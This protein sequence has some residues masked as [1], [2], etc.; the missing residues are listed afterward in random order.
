VLYQA[1]LRPD[2]AVSLRFNHPRFGCISL[3]S[4]FRFWNLDAAVAQQ[5]VVYDLT[6]SELALGLVACAQGFAILLLPP[7]LG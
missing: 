3:D 4:W 1:N 6:K 5:V 2:R 7:S